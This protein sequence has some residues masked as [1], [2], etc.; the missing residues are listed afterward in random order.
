MRSTTLGSA[1]APS[2]RRA[3]ARLCGAGYAAL[4]FA[5]LVVTWHEPAAP[6]W[7]WLAA[8]AAIALARVAP[9]GRL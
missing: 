5:M 3:I 6:R 7:P 2:R 8:L 4:A 9:A 1:P